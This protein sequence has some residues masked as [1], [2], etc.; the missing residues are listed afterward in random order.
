M[1]PSNIREYSFTIF[2]NLVAYFLYML[3][4]TS[5]SHI[6]MLTNETKRRQDV[7]VDDYLALFDSLKLDQKLKFTVFDCLKQGV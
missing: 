7:M 1:A 6:F 5:I 2:A 4:V 3:S